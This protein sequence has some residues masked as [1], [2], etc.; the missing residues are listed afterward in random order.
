MYKAVFRGELARP[1][2]VEV[3]GTKSSGDG[4]SGGGGY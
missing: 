1:L 2:G 3:A 4:R